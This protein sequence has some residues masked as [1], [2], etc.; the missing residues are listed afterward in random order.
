MFRGMAFPGEARLVQVLVLLHF[1]PRN[2][3]L[4]QLIELS[5]LFSPE[6]EQSRP[7]LMGVYNVRTPGRTKPEGRKNPASRLLAGGTE[8]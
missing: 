3:F 1:T 5:I 8:I 6:G 7:W 2:I 4:S